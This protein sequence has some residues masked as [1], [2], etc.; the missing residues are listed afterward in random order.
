MFQYL[1]GDSEFLP[2]LGGLRP[3]HLP[4]L[5][6]PDPESLLPHF[7]RT[8]LQTVQRARTAR[9]RNEEEKKEKKRQGRLKLESHSNPRHKCGLG[10]TT[11]IYI[12]RLSVKISRNKIMFGISSKII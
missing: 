4:L 10:S 7:R 2:A 6:P 1:G 9:K 3:L 8:E 12:C 11:L 5:R